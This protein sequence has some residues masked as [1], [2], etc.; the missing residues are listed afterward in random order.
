MRKC[1]ALSRSHRSINYLHFWRRPLGV[2]VRLQPAGCWP[3]VNETKMRMVKR[4][5][6]TR[7]RQPARRDFIESIKLSSRCMALHSPQTLALGHHEWAWPNINYRVLF[8]WMLGSCNADQ[9]TFFLINLSFFKQLSRNGRYLQG[10][11]TKTLYIS[12]L[13]LY[14]ATIRSHRRSIC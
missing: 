2:A 4:D 5:H 1:P 11:M 6:T 7:K 8:N 13:G 10:A 12:L 14:D 9:T 3:R